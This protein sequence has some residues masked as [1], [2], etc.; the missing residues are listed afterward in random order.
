MSNKRYEL[1]NSFLKFEIGDI[2]MPENDDNNYYNVNLHFRH[3]RVHIETILANPDY[4]KEVVDKEWEI[5]SFK[6]KYMGHN[7][8]VFSRG[9]DGI[10]RTGLN[11]RTYQYTEEEILKESAAQIFCVKRLSDGETF[12][13]GDRVKR[14]TSSDSF[15]IRKFN[16]ERNDKM[17]VN[18]HTFIENLKKLP[19]LPTP[20]T[21]QW[22]YELV[23]DFVRERII[24]PCDYLHTQ[25]DDRLNSFIKE[26]QAS[27]SQQLNK[28]EEKIESKIDFYEP[29]KES[30]DGSKFNRHPSDEY[31]QFSQPSTNKTERIEVRVF[32]EV[33]TSRKTYAYNFQVPLKFSSKYNEIKS[34]I[35]Q[36]LNDEAFSEIKLN[37]RINQLKEI[38][39]AERKAFEAGR[40]RVGGFWN[41]QIKNW[42]H[43][44]FEDY[45]KQN[46]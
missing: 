37:E 23:K 18:G 16:I 44:T 20:A 13:I 46:P 32:E 11:G 25:L 22:T 17:I 4:F 45:K 31:G 24:S 35:E 21:F 30:Y 41:E 5:V 12:S 34:A 29:S 10:F 36:V 6:T 14:T 39:K 8:V 1:I 28:E 9:A 27:K 26:R 2:F 42:E 3:E 40:K 43:P 38:E 19:T 33:D 7:E 15:I